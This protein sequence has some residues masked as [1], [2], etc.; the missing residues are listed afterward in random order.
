MQGDYSNASENI[1]TSLKIYDK[2]NIKNHPLLA[3]VH[4]QYGRL[5]DKINYNDEAHKSYSKA[6]EMRLLN[7]GKAHHLTAKSAT[8]IAR[9][10]LFKA[11]A[12]N[13]TEN[14]ELS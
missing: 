6:F 8:D 1:K 11:F 7:F 13:S 3:G 14:T 2:L 12:E 9:V 4:V 5:F 10:L